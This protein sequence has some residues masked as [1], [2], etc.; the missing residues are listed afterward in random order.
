MDAGD[1]LSDKKIVDIVVKEG[2]T[3]VREIIEWGARFDKEKESL[4]SVVQ[5]I[6]PILH[7]DN[8]D[9]SVSYEELFWVEM[10]QDQTKDYNFN[11]SNDLQL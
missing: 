8:V 6:A 7:Y 1:D 4:G 3:R 10:K 11:E 2:P 5:A 9:G